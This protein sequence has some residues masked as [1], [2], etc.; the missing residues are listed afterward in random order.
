M[1]VKILEPFSAIDI[2]LSPRTGQVIEIVDERRANKLIEAGLVKQVESIIPEGSIAVTKNGITNVS[3]YAQVEVKVTQWIIKFKNTNPGLE[4]EEIFNLAVVNGD[5]I[6]QET[7]NA[8]QFTVPEGKVLVGF[9]A[10]EDSEV[11]D[12][13]FPFTPSRNQTL[14]TVFED[15]E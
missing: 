3:T 14:Y 1:L 5:N 15:E 12:I 10:E 2:D 7:V 11:A 4:A 13:N 9:S 6:E 8:F